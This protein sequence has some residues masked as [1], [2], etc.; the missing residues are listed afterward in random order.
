MDDV[1]TKRNLIE[2]D[3]KRA[4]QP[5]SFPESGRAVTNLG[6][7]TRRNMERKFIKVVSPSFIVPFVEMFNN[8]MN[9]FE[10]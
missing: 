3:K 9:G 4:G 10:T 5:H 7:E 1:D 8:A 2:L 6:W